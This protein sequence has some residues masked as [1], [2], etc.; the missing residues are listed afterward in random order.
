MRLRPLAPLPL[1]SLAALALACA[2]AE[3]PL[4]VLVVVLDT[5][6]P[7][8]LGCYGHDRP[9]SPRLDALAARAAVFENAQTV[10][11]WTAP[12]LISL[13][14]SLHPSVHGVREFPSPARMDERLVTLAEVLRDRGYATGAFTE[15]GFAKGDFGLD[16]GFDAFPRHAGDDES[17]ASNLR[18]PSRLEATADRALA[19]LD[20]H[21]DEPFLLLFHTYE[22]HGPYHP[23][24]EDLVAVLPTWDPAAERAALRAAVARWNAQ[25]ELSDDDWRTLARHR[26]HCHLDEGG[27]VV[28]RKRLLRELQEGGWLPPGPEGARVLELVRAL[29]DAEIR[30]A[31]E[32]VGR[33]LDRLA[34][35]GVD[36]RTVVVVV[37]DHGEA[38]GEH[39]Q[40]GHGHALHEEALRIVLMVAAPGRGLP[41][42]HVEEVV[43][44]V[45]VMPTVLELVGAGGAAPNAQGAS[46][47]PLLEGGASAG[48]A[49]AVS[50]HGAHRDAAAA[51]G[52]VRTP[53]W[54]YVEEADG[55]G[56]LY[57]RAADPGET[58]DVAV[59]HPEVVAE[60][61]ERLDERRA[62]DAA[63]R[64]RLGA[65]TTPVT[66]DDALRREL[67]AL[68]YLGD[69][70]DTP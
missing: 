13:V 69:E 32:Q 57:D 19:W 46:L 47:V 8:R 1:A 50:G 39:G 48:D 37:S 5:L 52:T 35:R 42:R 11:P 40:V 4:N 38:F 25:E 44:L 6:R 29:Y 20:E 68:G 21:A 56:R 7:D 58:T 17:H 49:L 14:T 66:V 64:A 18:Y 34:Q 60:L 51:L 62:A 70:D 26:Y 43:S 15:G 61:R 2:P 10:A 30:F 53:R 31:D 27:E 28:R 63:L 24:D 45:D 67:G 9:T 33:L 59:A 65:R 23:R 41:A 22:P 55:A 16:Q 54:R 12:S 36:D 3:P